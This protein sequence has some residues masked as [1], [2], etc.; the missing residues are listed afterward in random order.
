[1]MKVREHRRIGE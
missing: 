1:M